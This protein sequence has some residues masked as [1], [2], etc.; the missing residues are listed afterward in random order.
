VDA[1]LTFLEDRRD[2]AVFAAAAEHWGGNYLDS[3]TDSGYDSEGI[4]YW[5]YGF[6][7]YNEMREQLW[8]STK[9]QLDLY[10]DAK[11]RRSALFGFQFAMLPGVYADLGTPTS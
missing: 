5:A 11:A 8:L 9:G 6:S 7:H 1:A 4:G 3:F 10:D 2:R